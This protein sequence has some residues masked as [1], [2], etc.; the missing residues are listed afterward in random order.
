MLY[1][2]DALHVETISQHIPTCYTS[3][4]ASYYNW[5]VW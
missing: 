5:T 2:V 3:D 1:V 4:D